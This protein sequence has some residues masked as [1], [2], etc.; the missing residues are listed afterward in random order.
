VRAKKG[1]EPEHLL[2]GLIQADAALMDRLLQGRFQPQPAPDTE[3]IQPLKASLVERIRRLPERAESQAPLS[4]DCK[5]VIEEA[6]READRLQHRRIST[7][8]FLLAFLSGEGVTAT[9]I[10]TDILAENG[11]RVKTARERV[12]QWLN[13]ESPH[14]EV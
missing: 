4:S 13:E 10:L 5:R 7:G 8:H 12:T 6:A 11:L 2:L 3:D 9:P 1:I 14:G